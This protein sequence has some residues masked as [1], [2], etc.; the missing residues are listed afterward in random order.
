MVY[1]HQNLM[2]DIRE[3]S[4]GDEM[5][6]IGNRQLANDQK[7]IQLLGIIAEK[8]FGISGDALF[9]SVRDQASN[10]TTRTG[11]QAFEF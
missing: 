10:Y 9:R 1:G 2:N 3:A 11:K 7:I 5:T 6:A 8:E 4:N